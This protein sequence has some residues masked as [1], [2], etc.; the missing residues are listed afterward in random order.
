MLLTT[1][2]SGLRPSQKHLTLALSAQRVA[3]FNRA[4]QSSF[5]LARDF[6]RVLWA[7]AVAENAQTRTFGVVLPAGVFGL[8]T[9]PNAQVPAADLT[10]CV[11]DAG[12]PCRAGNRSI[13]QFMPGI[14]DSLGQATGAAWLSATV[15]F[16]L[17]ALSGR[18][19]RLW[20]REDGKTRSLLR[21]GITCRRPC[22]E[23]GTIDVHP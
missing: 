11:S 17:I 6:G 2:Q 14:W 18:A 20:V 13:W 5:R 12:L 7:A 23:A 3:S 19:S 4:R 9:S 21:S 22:R 15:A 8:S 16:T 10:S 1:N